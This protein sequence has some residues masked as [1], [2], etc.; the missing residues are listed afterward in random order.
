MA[1]DEYLDRLCFTKQMGE[2]II[3]FNSQLAKQLFEICKPLNIDLHALIIQRLVDMIDKVLA[4]HPHFVIHVS[5]KDIQLKDINKHHKGI[6]QMTMVLRTRYQDKL[7]ICYIHQAPFVFQ[8]IYNII[9][10]FIDTKTKRK[11]VV[12]D[13]TTASTSSSTSPSHQL[14]A[15]DLMEIQNSFHEFT[16][17]S[18]PAQE[19]QT[20]SSA[21]VYCLR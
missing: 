13:N 16:I 17:S 7:K 20:N 21:Q 12:H 2:E 6:I 8:Q 1:L 4:V 19:E 10:P 15:D 5:M 14:N 11:I 3:I 9:S 18:P